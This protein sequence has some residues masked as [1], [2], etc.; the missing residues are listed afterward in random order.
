MHLCS[1]FFK[2]SVASILASVSCVAAAQ[3]QNF[4]GEASGTIYNSPDSFSDSIAAGPSASHFAFANDYE[5]FGGSIQLLSL[6]LEADS[7]LTLFTSGSLAPSTSAEARGTISSSGSISGTLSES[8]YYK[9]HWSDYQDTLDPTLGSD[10]SVTKVNLKAQTITHVSNSS[11]SQD[12]Y[13]W[14]G[15]LSAG[16]YLNFQTQSYTN[17][18]SGTQSLLATGGISGKIIPAPV[19]EPSSVL[20][21]CG[22]LVFFKK[23]LKA[24]K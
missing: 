7:R 10:W 9:F 20:A 19:P 2:L 17:S 1:K 18:A 5:T 24:K 16:T 6:T 14:Q 3:F 11:Y 22:G 23:R 12:D 13:I 8:G 15:Y 21:L 4:S